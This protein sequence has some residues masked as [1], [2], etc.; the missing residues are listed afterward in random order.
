MP[1]LD[2]ETIERARGYAR[3]LRRSLNRL[4]AIGSAVLE[5]H[6]IT[7]PQY[8]ALLWISGHEGLIQGDLVLE[9]DSD[10]NTVSAILRQLDKKQ[11][12]ERRRHPTDRR[13][14]TLF[15]TRQGK[16]LVGI[17]RP[18]MDRMTGLLLAYLPPGHEAAVA[19]WLERLA[20]IREIP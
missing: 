1:K 8:L 2:R 17:I 16:E 5:P 11:L 19:E 14:I 20:Q 4:K 10:P 6:G 13:A 12:I 15:A 7:E 9:L 3:L 18:Q